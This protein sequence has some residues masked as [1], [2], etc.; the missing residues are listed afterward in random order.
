M[1]IQNAE[2]HTSQFQNIMPA[3]ILK[4]THN[5]ELQHMG[6]DRYDS[7]MQRVVEQWL[8]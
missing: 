3:G 1:F 4:V 6:V 5:K 2:L 8:G 7:T